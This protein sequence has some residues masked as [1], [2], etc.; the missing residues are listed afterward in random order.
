MRMPVH[1]YTPLQ[2]ALLDTLVYMVC[3]RRTRLGARCC[4]RRVGA[5]RGN[6]TGGTLMT[7]LIALMY[8]AGGID[9]SI[10]LDMATNVHI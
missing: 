2:W 6:T 5:G 4:R 1:Y 8:T 10:L 3:H 9:V 7:L